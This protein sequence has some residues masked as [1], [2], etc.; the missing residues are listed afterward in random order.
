MEPPQVDETSQQDVDK[1]G[2]ATV[3]DDP[4]AEVL[5]KMSQKKKYL[6]L[7]I[8]I[9]AQSIDVAANSMVRFTH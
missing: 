1:S 3:V 4:A 7:A 8:F 2:T 5:S 6:L 9:M